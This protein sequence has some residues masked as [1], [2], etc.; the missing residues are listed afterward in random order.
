[1]NLS[2]YQ[3]KDT[4]LHN[5]DPRTKLVGVA[6]IFIICLCFNNPIYMAVVALCV[7]FIA[8]SARAQK[9]LWTLR[10]I[11]LLLVIFS[12]LLWPFF[13]VG[14]TPLWSWRFLRLTK[15]SL[16]YGIAMG[17]RLSTFVI[18][19]LILLSTTKNEDITNG[20]IK[21]KI[22]YPLA[23]AFSTALR[24]VPTFVGAGATIVQAQ[25]SRGLDLESRNIISRFGKFI[26]L[27]VPMFISAIRYTNLL[28]MALESRGFSPGS[29]RTLYYEPVMKR[30]DWLILSFMIIVLIACLYM[31]IFLNLGVVMSGRL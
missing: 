18:A 23:F 16:F 31:R 10:Y 15:E 22:P 14:K 30:R 8:L 7:F 29:P 1:M 27:A 28:S 13:T 19:G 21:M 17:I 11:L 4:W 9:A 5:I 6:I 2:L 26:P 3:D 24:L 25:V 20:L 12:V